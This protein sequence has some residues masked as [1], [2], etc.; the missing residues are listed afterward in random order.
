MRPTVGGKVTVKMRSLGMTL[1][2]AHVDVLGKHNPES[3]VVQGLM[4]WTPGAGTVNGKSFP[5]R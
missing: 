4:A 3:L 5:R 2:L 1:V